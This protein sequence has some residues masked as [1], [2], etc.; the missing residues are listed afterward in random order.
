MAAGMEDFAVNFV[1]AS[2]LS[3]EPG[4][5]A[6]ETLLGAPKCCPC[7]TSC[8][9]HQGLP[10]DGAPAASCNP[11][12]AQIPS[13][14]PCKNKAMR[15]LTSFPTSLQSEGVAGCVVLR[16]LNCRQPAWHTTKALKPDSMN[17]HGP[18]PS[19]RPKD[20]QWPRGHVSLLKVG[21]LCTL[22][23]SA[24]QHSGTQGP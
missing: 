13:S 23:G 12:M 4:W 2:V 21:L 8:S 6:T 7:R 9:R 15:S 10:F 1:A 24:C 18:E 20:A 17:L 22:V 3:H 14:K 11:S 16:L 19:A 5:N